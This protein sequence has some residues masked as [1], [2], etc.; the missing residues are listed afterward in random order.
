[1]DNFLDQALAQA[2]LASHL[3][4]YEQ[5]KIADE[6]I[7]MY[8]MD[9]RTREGWLKKNEEWMSL[10]LQ[11]VE[12]KSFPWDGASNV[13]YPLLTIAALQF[14][15]RAYPALVASNDIVKAKGFGP[16]PDGS[17]AKKASDI[18]KHIS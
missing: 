8:E 12:K 1:M 17:L 4:E 3:D 11:V 6:V 9:E 14:A 2:N 16:D 7:T 13:K 10:A 5:N 18:S 15:S